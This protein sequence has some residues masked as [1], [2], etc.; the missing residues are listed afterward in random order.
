MTQIVDREI[1]NL[2]FFW[3][4]DDIVKGLEKLVGMKSDS[5]FNNDSG[6]TS[7]WELGLNQWLEEL[8]LAHLYRIYSDE[9]SGWMGIDPGRLAVGVQTYPS[10]GKDHARYLFKKIKD[11]ESFNQRAIDN[12]IHLPELKCKAFFGDDENTVLIEAADAFES[13]PNTVS[14]KNSRDRTRKLLVDF[15]NGPDEEDP[16]FG[17]GLLE[18]IWFDDVEV[19]EAACSALERRDSIVWQAFVDW[20]DS[21]SVP[22]MDVQDAI[23]RGLLYPETRMYAKGIIANRTF[24]FWVGQGPKWQVSE[25]A[26]RSFLE[27][28][29]AS[30]LREII[31]IRGVYPSWVTNPV[32]EADMNEFILSILDH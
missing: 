25:D 16:I 2:L 26:L 7:E 3:E 23:L 22:H 31:D 18:T 29:N 20:G 9:T 15:F 6:Y 10:G 27:K 4:H 13:E 8:D 32:E 12:G 11:L 21:Y 5:F 19:I 14:R 17:S 30:T 24:H 28:C 1:I